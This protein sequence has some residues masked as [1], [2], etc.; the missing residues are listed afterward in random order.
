MVFQLPRCQA[1]AAG[2]WLLRIMKFF[3]V[4]EK[5]NWNIF[6]TNPEPYSF[7]S[8]KKGW[9]QMKIQQKW[10]SPNYTQKAVIHKY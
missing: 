3:T 6:G 2:N 1:V 9:F 8:F 5:S 7:S 10:K 4:L